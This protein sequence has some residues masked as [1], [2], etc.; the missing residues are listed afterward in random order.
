MKTF[1]QRIWQILKI[2]TQRSEGN[3]GMGSKSGQGIK[4]GSYVG[5]HLGE[6]I[7]L[8]DRKDSTHFAD[9]LGNNTCLRLGSPGQPLV[10]GTVVS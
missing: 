8:A 7:C 2:L 1:T 9:P 4:H 10:G 5:V 3:C 6:A